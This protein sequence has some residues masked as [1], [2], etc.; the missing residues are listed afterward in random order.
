MSKEV[1]IYGSDE[2]PY[3]EKLK[4]YLKIL[5]IDFKYINVDLD[6]NKGEYEKIVEKIGHTFIPTIS[7][8]GKM[9]SPE[10]DFKTIPEAVKIIVLD[11]KKF[12]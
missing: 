9:I 2:C 12:W 6:Q 8:D 10:E 4:K 1:K 3:C 11:L 5:R 7:I